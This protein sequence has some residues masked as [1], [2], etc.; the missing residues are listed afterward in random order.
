[1]PRSQERLLENRGYDSTGRI[2]GLPDIDLDEFVFLVDADG[3]YLVDSDGAFL[4]AEV[5]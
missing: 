5:A 4:I 1:M 2:K 3:A